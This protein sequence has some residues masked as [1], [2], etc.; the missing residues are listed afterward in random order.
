LNIADSRYQDSLLRQAKANGKISQDHA[1]PESAR[2]N[3]ASRL[4]AVFRDRAVAAHF[5][6]Y[7]FGTDLTPVEQQLAGALEYLRTSA[8]GRRAKATTL[9]AALLG[10]VDEQALPGLRRLSLDAPRS[11]H[12][13]V[14]RRL[15]AY[16]LK[17]SMHA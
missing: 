16:A 2:E 12:E 15:V 9:A 8:A 5:P 11:L 4:A 17:R 6:E 1:I 13:R 14:L 7:P 10:R 3:R